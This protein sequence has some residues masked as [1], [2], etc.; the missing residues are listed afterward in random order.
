[1][2]VTQLI[3]HARALRVA[4]DDP[5]YSGPRLVPREPEYTAA[6]LM[7]LE[8]GLEFAHFSPLPYDALV[9][10][11][12][13]F[14]QLAD[15]R[16]AEHAAWWRKTSAGRAYER[17]YVRQRC[18]RLKAIVAGK[19]RCAGCGHEFTVTVYQVRRGRDRVCSPQC[20]GRARAVER[21]QY[22]GQKKT[23]SEW[24]VELGVKLATAWAR[25]KRGWS[26]E[27]AVGIAMRPAGKFV[28]PDPK[29]AASGDHE[30]R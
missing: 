23:L 19:R 8:I 3:E 25:M 11:L 14:K 28:R 20:R 15:Q 16:W 10:R 26:F 5:P 2:S 7:R 17:A 22:R 21:Y 30:S 18:A 4:V 27:E 24:C 1:M 29:G 9:E 6:E 13:H 12:W